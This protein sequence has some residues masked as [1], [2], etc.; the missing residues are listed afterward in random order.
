[1]ARTGQGMK[2]KGERRK[3]NSAQPPVTV[4]VPGMSVPQMG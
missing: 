1:M 4:V 3:A 2:A